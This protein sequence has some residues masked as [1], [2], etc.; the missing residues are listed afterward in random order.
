M[1]VLKEGYNM[2]ISFIQGDVFEMKADALIFPANH[3]P[4]I[5]GSL[6]GQIYE[7]AGKEKLLPLREKHGE[8]HS[9][10][11]CMTESC[12]LNEKYSWLIHTATPVYQP[13]HPTNTMHKLKKCYLSALELAEKKGLKHIVFV[14]LG[15]GASGFSHSKAKEAA[16]SA[17]K[18]YSS[19]HP[20]SLIEGVTVVEYEKE[21]QYQLLIQC[22]RKLK[23][24]CELLS[25]IEG[26]EQF[27]QPESEIG[28]VAEKVSDA[29]RRITADKISMMFEDFQSEG[30]DECQS[31]GESPEQCHDRIYDSII[32]ENNTMSNSD[33]AD[34]MD[35]DPTLI[36]RII[37]ITEKKSIDRKAKSFWKQRK[38][39]LKLGITL[40]LELPDLCRLMWCRGHSFP[41]EQIDY[42]LIEYLPSE[43]CEKAKDTWARFYNEPFNLDYL[44]EHKEYEK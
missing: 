7:R 40:E 24:V 10:E 34:E 15:A 8:L 2:E 21:S 27:A 44:L 26:L 13:S 17:I 33:L 3:K 20:D 35:I 30:T 22:N 32:A 31:T 36:S 29:L 18:R 4:V 14:L 39:V 25:E 42:K 23:E 11:S 6:D 43:N 19:E 28:K 16:E 12:N 5:G 1:N 41:S 9:G 37:K 38:N